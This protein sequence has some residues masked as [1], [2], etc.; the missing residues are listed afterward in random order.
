MNQLMT[1]HQFHWKATA[2]EAVTRHMIFIQEALLEVGI[3][4]KIFAS[5]RKNLPQGKVQAWSLDNVWNCDLLVVHH[6]Q[7][8]PKLE[9]ILNLEIP[10]LFIYHS[11]PPERFYSHDLEL[12]KQLS[13]SKKQLS[14]IKKANVPVAA[15]S[16]FAAKELSELGFKNPVIIPLL[17]LVEAEPLSRGF[18]SD[19]SKNILF[20]GRIG[21]HKKQALLIESFSYLKKMLPKHSKLI[22]VGTGDALYSKYLKL[23]IKQWDLSDSVVLAGKVTDQ[24]LSHYYEM[25]ELFVCLSEHE[26]FCIPVV[27]AMGAGIPVFYRPLAGIKE[28][29]SN[30]GVELLSIDPVAIASVILGFLDNPSALKV[31]LERQKRRLKELSLFQNKTTI[32]DILRGFCLGGRRRPEPLRKEVKA[33]D[34]E[35]A[36]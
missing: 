8:N 18:E 36:L 26:G 27:E 12:K 31:V 17:H 29:M 22:L 5:E 6:S 24:D 35:V 28:T 30:A 33:Y 10:K 20:V 4:G 25:A 21:P 15:V 1:V 34:A 32:A 2:G 7:F 9:E 14:I 11:Q 19:Q 23:L 16:A 3:S 13:K